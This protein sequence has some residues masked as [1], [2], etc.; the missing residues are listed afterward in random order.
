MI[1]WPSKSSDMNPIK[2]SWDQK[3]VHNRDMI[4]L[5]TTAAQLRVAVQKPMATAGV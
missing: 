5:L 1:D 2:H 4:N 3:M